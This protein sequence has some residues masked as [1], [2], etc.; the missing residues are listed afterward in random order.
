LELA[1][2]VEEV[3]RIIAVEC[4]DNSLVVD[5]DAQSAWVL[6]DRVQ[7]Q[8]VLLN[9]VHNAIESMVD[10]AD[11]AKRIAIRARRDGAEML[12]EVSD[13]GC[14]LTDPA[15]VFE[16]FYTTKASGMGMGLAISRSIVEAHGG[17]LWASANQGLGTTFSFTLPLPL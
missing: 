8:Q 5:T 16:A 14:G 2:V 17:R 3:L 15:A 7:I 13:Q 1:A 12:I 6:G 9:L 10:V 4:R 11:G